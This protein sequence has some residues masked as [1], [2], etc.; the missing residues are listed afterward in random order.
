MFRTYSWYSFLKMATLTSLGAVLILAQAFVPATGNAS[1]NKGIQDFGKDDVFELKSIEPVAADDP[2]L[3][4]IR[5]SP[6]LTGLKIK[7]S[8]WKQAYMG[9]YTN[10]NSQL[11]VMPLR[12]RTTKEAR[13]LMVFYDPQD[14]NK[15]PGFLMFRSIEDRQEGA[16]A[17]QENEPGENNISIETLDGTVLAVGRSRKDKIKWGEPS[18]GI[19]AAGISW[20]CFRGCFATVRITAACAGYCTSC[21]G[22]LRVAARF[23]YVCAP[24]C[25][26]C[27]FCLGGAA[28][29]CWNNCSG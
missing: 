10:T 1:V 14:L 4:H 20:S 2:A 22:C 25:I 3:T 11:L 23:P 24:P 9:K 27:V 18:G 12:Q 26:P 15:K 6:E 13:V 7:T 5:N 29:G 19:Q 17:R 28:I 16:V 21:S 8:E